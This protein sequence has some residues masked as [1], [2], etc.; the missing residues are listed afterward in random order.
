MANK[1]KVDDEL[2]IG[3][4]EFIVIAGALCCRK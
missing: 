3:G 4:D 1:V 2:I